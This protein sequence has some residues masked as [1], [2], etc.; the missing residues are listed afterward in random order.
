[1]NNDKRQKP[2]KKQ[3][4]IEAAAEV[5]A[6]KGFSGTVMADI[7]S[8]AGIGKGTIYEYFSSKDDLFFSVFE[9]VAEQSASAARVGISALTGSVSHRLIRMNDSIMNYFKEMEDFFSLV[10]E[11]WSASASSQMRDR[12]KEAFRNSYQGLRQIVASLVRDGINYGEFRPDVDPEAIAAALVGTWDALLLQGW[13]D[14]SFDP[15]R[16]AGKYLPVLLKGMRAEP[17]NQD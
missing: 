14:E 17:G 8:R 15:P 7:A 13:F 6:R 4:I 2:D 16:T 3:L 11:F 1:M 9:W 5:F 12:F 10:M